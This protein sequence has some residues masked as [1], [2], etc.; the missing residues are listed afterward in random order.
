MKT[1][2]FVNFILEVSQVLLVFLGVYS[3]LMCTALSL[4]LPVS[5]LAATIILLASAFLFYGLFTVLETF[6]KGKLYGMLGIAAFCALVVLRFH[7]VLQKGLVTIVNVYL[8]A[9]MDYSQTTVTLISNHGFENET[10]SLDYC[11]TFVIVFA[12]VFLTALISCFFYRKRRS[13]VYI[14]ATVWFFLIPITVGKMGYFS[15]VITY[16]FVTMAVIGTRYLRSDTTDKRM[17]QKL[18]FVFLGVGLFCGMVTYLF[19]PPE[20]YENN[21][22]DI[23]EMKNSGLALLTWERE[24]ISL[25][26][27]EYF[28]GDAMEYGKIGRKNSINRTGQTML[29]LSGDMDINHGLYFKGYVGNRYEENRWHQIKDESGAYDKRQKELADAGLALDGWHITLRNQIGESQATGNDKLWSTGKITVKNISFGYGNYLV[30][31]YPTVAFTSEGGRMKVAEPGIQY[32]VEYYPIMASEMRNGI[33]SGNYSLADNDYWKSSEKNRTKLKDFAQKYY[34]DVPQQLS[35]VIEDY[36]KYLNSQDSLY[37]KFTRGEATVEQIVG[38]TRDY[39]MQ[40]T[41]YTL[42]PGKTP[43]GKDAVV[44]F[45]QENKKGYS[46]HYATAAAL[47]LRGAGI[48]TRYVEG[49]YVSGE[50]IADLHAGS[51]EIQVTDKDIHAWVEVYQENYGFVPLEFTPGMGEEEASD[52]SV[53]KDGEEETAAPPQDGDEAPAQIPAEKATPEPE[54]DMTF[55][56]IESDDYNHEEPETAQSEEPETESG[57]SAGG[58]DAAGPDGKGKDGLAWW[59]MALVILAFPVLFVA[60]MEGQRRLRMFLYEQHVRGRRRRKR[61]LM[62]YRHLELALVYMGVR[63]RGQSMADYSGLIAKACGMEVKEVYPLVYEVFRASYGGSEIGKDEMI[64]F[65]NDYRRVKQKIYG[66]QK[67]WK[68]L[69]FMYILAL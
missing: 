64:Q 40:D 9:F 35:G 22:T 30:P 60:V 36:K 45:L 25:W 53:T 27:R 65:C 47:L 26:L 66:Q 3:A 13:S 11:T 42:S 57:D 51:D 39:I 31:Y 5:R 29:K 8:K 16:I 37:D 54:E 21:K 24:D 56:N 23:V 58:A 14:A 1:N 41:E 48:P 43:K 2:K 50:R 20:R 55:E 19:L 52:S 69:Y 6:R 4:A 12:G 7:N 62:Y 44:Y 28:S 10:A 38:E 46:N 15:N 59:Q 61:I 17:R 18:S 49:V 32:E 68:K 34:L 33:A 67:I 63:Y